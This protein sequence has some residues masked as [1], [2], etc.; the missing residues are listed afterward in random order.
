MADPKSGLVLVRTF[1]RPC[2]VTY[3]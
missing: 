1:T 2:S 3:W